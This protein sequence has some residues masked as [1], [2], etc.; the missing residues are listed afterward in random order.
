M[1]ESLKIQ[2]RTMKDFFDNS[3]AVLTE[4]DSNYAPQPEMLT[5]AQHVAH[6]A[7]TI[8]WF[9]DGAFSESGFDLNWDEHMEEIKKIH[10]LQDARQWMERAVDRVMDSLDDKTESEWLAKIAD[11]PIMGKV[12]RFA[13]FNAMTDHTAHHRGALTVY[14][15][16]VNK[17]P[18]MPYGG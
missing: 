1:K 7:H 8:E 16:L 11:G 4:D 15:R 17:T 6:T 9:L 18:A 12:P 2:I 5:V 10:S 3:T 13:I 14:A